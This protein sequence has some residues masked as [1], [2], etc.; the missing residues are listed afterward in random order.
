[1]SV[2]VSPG[3]SGGPLFNMSGA[4]VGITTAQ[5]G[6]SFGSAQNLNLAVPVNELKKLVKPEYPE[7][8]K[9]GE[10]A[11]AGAS[12]RSAPSGSSDGS[13]RFD[14]AR[15]AAVLPTLARLLGVSP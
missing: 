7:R 9:L 10:R 3:N 8:R 14:E 11:M 5:I 13:L 2:P 1:M 4:V 12:A 15:A 6:G